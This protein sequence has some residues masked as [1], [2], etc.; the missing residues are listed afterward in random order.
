MGASLEALVKTEEARIMTYLI[1]GTERR[2][3]TA[4]EDD[5]LTDFLANSIKDWS[6]LYT[7]SVVEIANVS[8]APSILCF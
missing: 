7:F 5:E 3:K 1:A 4:K 6:F 2:G 8:V